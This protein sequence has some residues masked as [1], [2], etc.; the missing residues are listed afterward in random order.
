MMSMDFRVYRDAAEDLRSIT[1]H[2][3]STVCIESSV[4]WQ[5]SIIFVKQSRVE[6][7]KFILIS[8]A[9]YFK[10]FAYSTRSKFIIFFYSNILQ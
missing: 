3:I 10:S 7:S 9:A 8:L 4:Y 5:T 1:S 2:L 6:Y